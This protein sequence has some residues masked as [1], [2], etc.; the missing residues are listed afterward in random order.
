[1]NVPQLLLDHTT[2]VQFDQIGGGIEHPMFLPAGNIARSHPFAKLLQDPEVACGPQSI[3]DGI[4]H[5]PLAVRQQGVQPPALRHADDEMDVVREDHIPQEVV[6]LVI[7]RAHPCIEQVVALR[8]LE[9]RQPSVAGERGEIRC[10]VLVPQLPRG[11]HTKVLRNSASGWLRPA[12]TVHSRVSGSQGP[13]QVAGDRCGGSRTMGLCDFARAA[14]VRSRS[15][16]MQCDTQLN[17]W[18]EAL[19]WVQAQGPCLAAGDPA[20]V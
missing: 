12:N 10:T 4:G 11:H 5:E 16:A 17:E 1:M 3:D 8:S 9:Q 18:S 2:A 19:P 7:A 15:P 6:A 13:R 14:I 20:E